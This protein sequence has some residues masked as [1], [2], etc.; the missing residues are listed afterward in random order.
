MSSNEFA[1]ARKQLLDYVKMQ[2]VGPVN[3]PEEEIQD[4]PHKRYLSGT[5][6]PPAVSRD[7]LDETLGEDSTTEALSNDFKPSSMALSFAAQN[8]SIFEVH[9]SAARYSRVQQSGWK[10]TPL[11]YSME[12]NLTKTENP[13]T[14]IFDNNAR[15]DVAVRT[16]VSGRIVTVAFSNQTKSGESLKPQDCFYQCQISITVKEGQFAE[17]PSSDRFKLDDEQKELA[18]T[19]RNRVSW[20]V[21]HGA[22]VNWEKQD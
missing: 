21:G 8:S 14:P 1:F 11:E 2:L 19:Y 4:A 6:F 5:L 7:D 10:R 20:G 3:G 12:V 22:A 18:L 16:Y 17:Y 15:L 13:Y 9:V